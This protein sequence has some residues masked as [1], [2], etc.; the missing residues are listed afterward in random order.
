[1]H[2]DGTFVGRSAPEIDLFE[3]QYAPGPD[4]S[5]THL[6]SQ[7]CQFGPFDYN[8]D[9]DKNHTTL[10]NTANT[11]LNEFKGGVYQESI[12]A[13]TVTDQKAYELNGGGY[14]VYGYEYQ[15]GFDNAYITWVS[16]NQPSWTVFSSAVGA[17][18]TVEISARPIP[19]EPMYIL[20]N[21]AL[22]MGFSQIDFSH[23]TFPATMRVDYIRVYQQPGQ[24]NIGC[25]P[26]GFPT[27]AYINTYLEAYSNPN[28]TMWDTD[29]GQPF[30][31]N[32]R[33]VKC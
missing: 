6:V 5:W 30:P 9:Y 16:N 12:S 14:S 4:G 33:V 11:V 22:S 3:A 19:Q 29:F 20:M 24:I 1:M 18:P 23:L 13:L 8:Y 31:K 21:L 2:P 32:S 17:D 10:Y 25:D 15:P 7:S 26:E 27:A 28:L